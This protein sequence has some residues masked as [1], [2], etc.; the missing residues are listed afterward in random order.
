MRKDIFYE[1]YAKKL[2]DDY[3]KTYDQI[4]IYIETAIQPGAD[5]CAIMNEVVDLLL[6]AQNDQQPVESVIG[7]DIQYF[8]DQI[9]Q[10]NNNT[11]LEKVLNF[12]SYY[13][14]IALIAFLFV[15]ADFLIDYFDGVK[16]PWNQPVT[17]GGFIIAI[18]LSLI[19]FSSFQFCAKQ[20]IF[21]YRWYT[22]R[23]HS[24]LT[25]LIIV[26]LFIGILFL[27]ET[28]DDYI[29]LPRWLFLIMT[30]VLFVILTIYKKQ[31]THI[32][33]QEDNHFSFT[34]LVLDENINQLRKKYHKYCLKC[35]K[36]AI[37]PIPVQQWYEKQYQKDKFGD[38]MGS[39]LFI[40][41]CLVFI[42]GTFLTSEFLDALIFSIFLLLI[43]IPIYRF[44][45][46]GRKAR[47]Q[48]YK[49]IH[50]LHTDIFDDQLTRD[51]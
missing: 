37:I 24:I 9:I 5:S 41:L 39:L 32:E 8:C 43:E 38:Q 36:K 16:T 14:I 25:T 49:L 15:G 21:R 46:K 23:I 34:D 27:P 6:S 35:E 26:S 20:L 18:A 1:D 2:T 29:F 12:L 44:A 19:I 40:V 47:K 30:S 45:D 10:S 51:E 4:S 33:I 31:Q 11:L 48:L 7:P 3:K 28:F 42:I 22:K 13:R 17:M 50:H